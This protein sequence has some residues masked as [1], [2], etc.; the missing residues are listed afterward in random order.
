MIL[1]IFVDDA[2]IGSKRKEDADNLVQ[3]LVDFVDLN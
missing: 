2:G 1:V 3:Q